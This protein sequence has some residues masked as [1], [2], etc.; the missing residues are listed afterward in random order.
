MKI[1]FPIALA[2]LLSASIMLAG[3]LP[4]LAEPN[5]VVF[6]DLDALEHYTTVTR[7]EVTEHMLTSPEALAAVRNGEPMPDGTH[8][9]LVDYRGG[10]VFRYFVMQKGAGW[11][12]GYGNRTG[13]WQYQ[14]FQP[15][16]SVNLAED[17]TRCQSCHQSRGDTEFMYTYSDILNPR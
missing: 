5:R 12:A 16:R 1:H 10:D 2:G 3:I 7:G 15:D 6:P 17:T 8:V 14:W 9:V 13:D 11:G 4:A